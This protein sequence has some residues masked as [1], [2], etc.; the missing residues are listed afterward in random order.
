MPAAATT[1]LSFLRRPATATGLNQ[2]LSAAC[3]R[4]VRY[5]LVV[6]AVPAAPIEVGDAPAPG[7]GPVRSQ[8]GMLREALEHPLVAHALK[9]FDAA[10]RKVEP[11]R[12]RPPAEFV[13]AAAGGTVAAA[14]ASEE[15]AAQEGPPAGADGE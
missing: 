14:A 1:A 2:A 4:Q 13:A 5:Q 6:E 8:A 9:L 7:P 12:P 15:V 10:V 3:G 11:A